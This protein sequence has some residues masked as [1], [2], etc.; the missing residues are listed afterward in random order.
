MARDLSLATTQADTNQKGAV[1]PHEQDPRLWKADG[2]VARIVKSVVG[3]L[4]KR[5]AV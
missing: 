1:R 5:G 4:R 3:E 2:W